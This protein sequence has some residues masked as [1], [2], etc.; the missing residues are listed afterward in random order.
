MKSSVERTIFW[1]L[2]IFIAVLSLM[3]SWNP[4]NPYIMIITFVGS[5]I[6]WYLILKLIFWVVRKLRNKQNNL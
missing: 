6:V 3:G 5:L 4:L 1:I 2:Y